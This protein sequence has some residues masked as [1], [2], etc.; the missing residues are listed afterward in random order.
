MST[1]KAYVFGLM[2]GA[3]LGLLSWGLWRASPFLLAGLLLFAMAE[4]DRGTRGPS[5]H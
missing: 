3:A 2:W 5:G 4:H 1:T